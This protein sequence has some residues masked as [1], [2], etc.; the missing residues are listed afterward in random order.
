MIEDEIDK[1]LHTHFLNEQSNQTKTKQT[2][3]KIST[4]TPS[5][6][7]K[8]TSTQYKNKSLK[9]SKKTNTVAQKFTVV[10]VVLLLF[11]VATIGIWSPYLMQQHPNTTNTISQEYGLDDTGSSILSSHG[12]AYT[13][14]IYNPYANVNFNTVNHYKANLHTHTMT[15]RI[16]SDGTVIFAD[17]RTLDPD[18]NQIQTGNPE[19]DHYDQNT[20][21]QD[22]WDSNG[23]EYGSDG[24]I[25]ADE[26]IEIYSNAEY[27]ILAITDHNKNTW[28]WTLWITNQPSYTSD[29]S[30][31]FPDLGDGGVLAISGIEPSS[32]HHFCFFLSN[33]IS[34]NGINDLGI[35]GNDGGLAHF[36]HPGRYDYLPSWYNDLYDSHRDYLIGQEV[37]NKRDVEGHKDREIWDQI[38]KDRNADDL[39]WGFANDDFHRYYS[40]GHPGHG[41]FLSY[42]HIL[43]DEL[44]ESSFRTALQTGAFYFSHEPNGDNQQSPTYGQADTPTL[45]DVTITDSIITIS[46]LEYTQIQWYDDTTTVVGEEESID[47]ST[48]NSNFVRAVLINENGR[49]YTQPF[50]YRRIPL[51]NPLEKPG[52]ELVFHDEFSAGALNTTVWK[53]DVYC[54]FSETSWEPQY[55]TNYSI[56]YRYIGPYNLPIGKRDSNFVFN[57]APDPTEG[58]STPHQNPSISLSLVYRKEPGL[59]YFPSWIWDN[60][61]EHFLPQRGFYYVDGKHPTAA[62]GLKDA[63]YGPMN[64]TSGWIQTNE[65]FTYGYFEMRCRVPNAGLVL[66]PA[67]W[68]YAADDPDIYR[69]IDIFEFQGWFKGAGTLL[70]TP[71]FNMH[72]K[73]NKTHAMRSYPGYYTL[74]GTYANVSD[75][76]HIYAVRWTPNVVEWYVDNQLRY[77]VKGDSPY[78]W[79][80]IIANLSSETYEAYSTLDL[81]AE[82]EIDYI[83]AYRS[84]EKEF[85]T[86]W[87]NYEKNSVI[88]DNGAIGEWVFNDD[89]VFVTGDFLG[90]GVDRLLSIH[91]ETGEAKLLQ[92]KAG[93]WQTTWHNQ[94][95]PGYIGAWELKPDHTYSFLSADF[96]GNNKDELLAINIETGEAMLLYYMKGIWNTHWSSAQQGGGFTNYISDGTCFVFGDV[97]GNGVDELYLSN[98]D[99]SIVRLYRYSPEEKT[100]VLLWKNL[101]TK[102]QRGLYGDV[103]VLGDFN[104]DGQHSLL[105]VNTQSQKA[106]LYQFTGSGWNQLWTSGDTGKINGW[107]INPNDVFVAGD[108]DG[109]GKDNL[110][111]FSKGGWSAMATYNSLGSF[112]IGGHFQWNWQNEGSGTINRWRMINSIIIPDPIE[113]GGNPHGGWSGVKTSYPVYFSGYFSEQTQF[114]P[115][116]QELLCLNDGFGWAHLATYTELP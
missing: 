116:Y 103:A 32:Q 20:W 27:G 35:L 106:W 70:N 10:G 29:S 56:D 77:I 7:K 66:W 49:T 85:L 99:L 81:P 13:H 90:D 100:W 97:T 21:H 109:N 58:G 38:N 39:V 75:Y 9:N 42:Q 4:T 33:I 48:I 107:Y 102:S 22:Y 51:N 57:A 104:G 46:G 41:P 95:T 6:S 3:T 110:L 78:A 115:M 23:V 34:Y 84:L 1:V 60:W 73:D 92:Y 72:L 8:P 98:S 112:G 89:D 12:M 65:Q 2:S 108:F 11:S 83:R 15:N 63:V 94:R 114:D 111:A 93:S 54:H 88:N 67:F 30:A 68:L 28:P 31:F 62:G 105:V 76:F 79:M 96:T 43:M 37:Y 36:N 82:F 74:E 91:P 45:T 14:E 113:G 55:Y 86:D 16:E 26:V 71:G 61:G 80:N 24:W 50:G 87:T 5:N 25:Y 47:V 17:G 53:T 44:T 52:W 18:G 101:D 19:W 69:E 64:D 59:K 40:A